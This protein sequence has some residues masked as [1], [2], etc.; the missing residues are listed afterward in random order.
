MSFSSR[1]SEFL[2]PGL[3]RVAVPIALVTIIL[4]ALFS[5]TRDTTSSYDARLSSNL[6]GPNGAK[7]IYDVARRLGWNAERRNRNPFDSIGP[8]EII[9]VLAPS[10]S[11]SERE[12]SV[13]LQRVR[14]GASLIAIV[15]KGS[16]LEDSLELPISERYITVPVDRPVDFNCPSGDSRGT[17][18]VSSE[19]APMR[20]FAQTVR[21]PS[22]AQI[23]AASTRRDMPWQP[24]YVA[25]G[26]PLGTGRVVALADANYL[27]ND[28][29]RVCKWGLGVSAVRMLEFLSA[30]KRPQDTRIVFDEFHQGFG[31]QASITRA[32]GKLLFRTKWGGL[33]LQVIAA[34]VVLLLAIS[35]RPIPPVAASRIQRRSQFEHVDALSSAYQQ[36]SA[37][38]L[39]TETLLRGLRRRLGGQSSTI[40]RKSESD[41]SF[42]G[43]VARS[44]PQVSREVATVSASLTE[45][46]SPSRLRDTVAAIE[47]IERTIKR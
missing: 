29:L 35:P 4:L 22:D 47:T 36:I 41:E 11:L 1:L 46:S 32:A 13:L 27:R 28:F 17:V 10:V 5:P 38:R 21:R 33:L 15:E 31:P 34:S 19:N 39:V 9:A 37:T 43:H 6:S 20:P 44:F 14:D 3:S 18:R 30:G 8:G 12:T 7:G 42:L 25:M 23:F 26:F 45:S 24:R 16:A 2:P 40:A